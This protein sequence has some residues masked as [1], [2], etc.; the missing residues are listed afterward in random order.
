V[1]S[2]EALARFSA[3]LSDS[4]PAGN[5]RPV[6]EGRRAAREAAD[7]LARLGI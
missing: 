6:A 4:P 3:A 1:T 7:E 2:Y 5:T